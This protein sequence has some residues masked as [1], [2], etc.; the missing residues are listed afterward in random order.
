[1]H[2]PETFPSAHY[3]HRSVG[4]GEA[5]QP[6]EGGCPRN[7]SSSVADYGTTS[8]RTSES[9]VSVQLHLIQLLKHTITSL[10][11]GN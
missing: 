10:A 5:S 11:C 4:P 3:R 2:F 1:M 9:E 8:A 6:E 7:D